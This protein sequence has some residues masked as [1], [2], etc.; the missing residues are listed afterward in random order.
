MSYGMT[1]YLITRLDPLIELMDFSVGAPILLF[2]TLLTTNLG[3]LLSEAGLLEETFA[4]TY[5]KY[6]ALPNKIVGG[7]VFLGILSSSL[8]TFI[9]TKKDA[10]VILGLNFAQTPIETLTKDMGEMYP[11]LKELVKQE[12]QGLKKEVKGE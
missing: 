7:I 5:K 8:T 10:L 6:F 2:V 9:P 4:A 12:L 3:F 11:E 1:Y